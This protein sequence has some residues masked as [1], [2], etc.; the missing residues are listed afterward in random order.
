MP[1]FEPGDLVRVP[2][3]HADSATRQFR[4]AIVVSAPHLVTDNAVLWVIMVTSA[5]NRGW[6]GDVSLQDGHEAMGLPVPS[7]ART[8][9]IATIEAT[10]AERRGHIG[11]I[12]LRQVQSRVREHLGLA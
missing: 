3:P 6:P 9:K 10:Q 5:E 2:F 4:P 8:A 7:L 11:A 12:L 1:I